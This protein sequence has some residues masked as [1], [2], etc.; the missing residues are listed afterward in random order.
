MAHTDKKEP[1]KIPARG[2]TVP[3]EE[4]KGVVQMTSAVQQLALL[5]TQEDS[6]AASTATIPKE[7]KK[8]AKKG[9]AQVFSISTT[10]CRSEIDLLRHI[11]QTSGW[12]VL[13]TGEL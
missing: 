5:D 3:E 13:G 12:K 1:G 8:K 10:N 6:K 4:K 11:I 7:D 9:K 2:P